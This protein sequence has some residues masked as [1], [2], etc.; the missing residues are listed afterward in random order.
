MDYQ[1]HFA[2]QSQDYYQYR[3][4]YPSELFAYL[5]SLVPS[6]DLAW[7]CATGNGQAA[8]GLAPFFKEVIATD[9]LQAQ[10]DQAPRLSNIQYSAYPAEHT[11]LQ[12]HSVDLITVAQALH[13]LDFDAFYT[14]SKRVLK[15]NGVIAAWCYAV[16]HM[17]PEIDK[18]VHHLYAEILGDAFWPPARKYIDAHYQ[19]IPFP[20]K[21][22]DVPSFV[23]EKQ[24][25]VDQF[26]GYLSTWSAVK[27][28]QER[29]G[30]N[31]LDLIKADLHKAFGND[32][33]HTMIW[34]LHILVGVMQE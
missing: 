21:K 10:L 22:R 17:T 27:E 16:G 6:H 4:V 12:S 30:K 24:Y 34:P 19:T 15:P 2:E 25:T 18:I 8:V 20:F 13:W 7:D 1:D 29:T 33:T 9:R 28:Y 31:P 5:A 32:T 23:M 3:P 26:L 11:L 14:E